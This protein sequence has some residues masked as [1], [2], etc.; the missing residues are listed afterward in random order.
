MASNRS[1]VAQAMKLLEPHYGKRFGFLGLTFKPGTDDLRESPTLDLMA[2]LLERGEVV[3]AFDPNLAFG[4]M[5]E[6]QI[7]YVRRAV[8][9]QARL[10]DELE[11][12]SVADAD[13]LVARSDV[14]VV[15]HATEAFRAA[16]VRISPSTHVV[17]LARLNRDMASAANYHG[18]AW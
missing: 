6:S 10:M 16:L 7:S 8:P 1:H 14:I 15:S 11:T 13:A 4:P 17:D 12:L 9:R 3:L 5:L 18:I 2:E